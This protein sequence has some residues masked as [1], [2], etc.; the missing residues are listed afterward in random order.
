[1]KLGSGVEWGVHCCLTLAWLD[2]EGPVSTGKLAAWFDVPP[3]YLK[4]QLQALTRAGILDSVAGVQGGFTLARNPA[5]ITL[6][7][8]VAALEGPDELF[9]CTEIRQS[10]VG[11]LGGGSEFLHPCGVTGAMR[12]AELAWRRE[13]AAQT[14]AD[15]MAASPKASAERTQRRYREMNQ[16]L[17]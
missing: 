6:M 11:G 16:P 17:A 12:R 9:R 13:L 10:G 15:L 7:D 2:G 4:K 1:M 3:E 14:I 8:V 5:N